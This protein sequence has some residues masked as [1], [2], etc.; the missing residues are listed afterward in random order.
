MGTRL[1]SL[2]IGIETRG[3][4]TFRTI[5]NGART[6][7]SPDFAAFYMLVPFSNIGRRPIVVTTCNK[8]LGLYAFM[9]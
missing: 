8:Y 4:R 3:T 9:H 2:G 1:A 7:I 6:K 5:G